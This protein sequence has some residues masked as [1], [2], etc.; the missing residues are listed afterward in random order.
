MISARVEVVAFAHLESVERESAEAT[1]RPR[2]RHHTEHHTHLLSDAR[3]A[4]GVRCALA[5]SAP[6]Y[7]VTAP[8]SVSSTQST[9]PSSPRTNVALPSS[10]ATAVPTLVG[11]NGWMAAHGGA[12][13]ASGTLIRS[14]SGSPQTT[15]PSDSSTRVAAAAGH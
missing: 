15:R 4:N 12:H 8:E 10:I 9:S 5:G 1:R 11:T 3:V 14:A 2:R 7:A 13:S 6:P